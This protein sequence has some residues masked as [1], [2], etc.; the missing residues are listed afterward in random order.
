M[1]AWKFSRL[2]WC[3][4]R[5]LL[6][7]WCSTGGWHLQRWG[8]S[9]RWHRLS[10]GRFFAKFNADRGKIKYLTHQTSLHYMNNFQTSKHIV[11]ELNVLIRK[12]LLNVYYPNLRSYPAY[13]SYKDLFSYILL[14]SFFPPPNPS[15]FFPFLFLYPLPCPSLLPLQ[16][17]FLPTHPFSHIPP[18]PPFYSFPSPSSQWMRIKI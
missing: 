10:W 2:W 8:G 4:S 17:P 3:R 16:P 6:P 1:T 7:S 11:F 13:L 5:G 12:L 15:S 9:Q 18:F 14:K